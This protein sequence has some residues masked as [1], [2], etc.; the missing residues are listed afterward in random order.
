MKA[1]HYRCFITLLSLFG[2]IDVSF[3]DFLNECEKKRQNKIPLST[4]SHIV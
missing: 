2:F 3:G 4:S 1:F